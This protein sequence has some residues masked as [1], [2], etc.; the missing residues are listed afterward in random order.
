[1]S[2]NT[3]VL[4]LCEVIS[5]V[6]LLVMLTVVGGCRSTST[7][8]REAPEEGASAPA[9]ETRLLS[10]EPLNLAEL[11]GQPVILNFWAS[12]CGPC[13]RE[14]P[15]LDRANSQAVKVI[16]INFGES[17]EDVA[18]FLAEH[19][20]SLPVALDPDG[21]V[22][23]RYRVSALPTSFFIDAQGIIRH[24]RAGE[25]TA[26]ALEAGLKAVR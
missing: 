20:V 15:L 23:R 3:P 7:P 9:F 10:G 26:K 5:I 18:A 14:L 1:M 17:E 16:A 6:L 21:K 24:K 25:V 12:W 22:A 2:P 19:P 4:R 13:A 11:R 8:S